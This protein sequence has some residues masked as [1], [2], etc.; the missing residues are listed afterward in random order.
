MALM[1]T[2]HLSILVNS[3]DSHFGL[4]F[5]TLHTASIISWMLAKSYNNHSK[6]V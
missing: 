4:F 1:L 5:T 3:A 6:N 2:S